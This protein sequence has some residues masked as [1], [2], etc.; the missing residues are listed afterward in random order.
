[1]CKEKTSG[2]ID[3]PGNIALSKLVLTRTSQTILA[4]FV[5]EITLLLFAVGIVEFVSEPL[6]LFD[7]IIVLTSGLLEITV[8]RWHRISGLLVFARA[9]RFMS[10]LHSMDSIR[11]IRVAAQEMQDDEQDSIAEQ[12]Q[13]TPLLTN[14]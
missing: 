13:N 14:T 6:Y 5:A 4:V 2:C 11:R 1:M 9:W 10:L 3:D 7:G 8:G 12:Q